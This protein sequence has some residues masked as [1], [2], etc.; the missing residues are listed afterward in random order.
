MTDECYSINEFAKIVKVHP[1]TIR[2]A[3]KSGRIIAFKVGKVYRISKYEISRMAE[4]DIEDYIEKE[5]Q[6]RL[7][8]N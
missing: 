5:V 1:N 6:K 4:F 8:G 7:G 3:I 2:R